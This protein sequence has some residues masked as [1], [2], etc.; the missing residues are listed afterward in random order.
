M[1]N[2]SHKV[3]VVEGC[4]AGHIP[5]SV[6]NSTVPL[7]LKDFGADWPVVIAG[8][9]SAQAAAD[10]IQS[11]YQG[12]PVNACFGDPENQGRVFYN[13]A[14]DGFNY[15]GS[16]VDLAL[17]L[18]KL[19]SHQDDEHP[20]TMYVGSTEINQWLPGFGA[21]NSASC[22]TDYKPLTSIWIGNKTSIAAHYD[23][24]N[25]I[26]C[27][28]V[29]RRRF[30][31]FPPEQISNLYVGPIEFAPGGQEISLVDFNQ[32]DYDQYPKF[33]TAVEAAQVAEL[34]PGDALFLPSMWW[35]HVQGL[36]AFNVLVSHWWRDSPAFMGR[37][38]NALSLAILSLRS[39]P[40]EQR[41]AWKHI[42]NHYIFDHQAEDLDHIPP[43]AR[44]I[45]NHPLDEDSARH[46]RADLINKLK[47]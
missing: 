27:S 6:L 44:S 17:V 20:P 7:L 16:Q 2:I 42:F 37:P 24:P 14:M 31:L 45:L 11:F 30:T 15:T 10:Y 3:A 38:N 13:Q 19:L 9:Q 36:D 41:Q 32:P 29:G 40:P 43:S 22:L 1:L 8:K 12:R 4:H 35:H 39:L 28:V 25:N 23:F 21:E 34:E 46:L 5:A 47:R 26:A 18:D 33:K